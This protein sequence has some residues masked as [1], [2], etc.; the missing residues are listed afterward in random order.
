[1]GVRKTPVIGV[2]ALFVLLQSLAFADEITDRARRLL[3]E[4]NPQAAYQLLQPLES[5]RAGDPEYDYL[6]GIAALDSG[7]R[8]RAVFALERVLAVNPNH[9]QA[10]AEIARAYF[11]L[12]EKENALREFQNVRATNPPEAVKQTIDRYLSALGVGATQLSGFLEIGFG[13]DSNVNSATASNQIAIPALGGIVAT[14]APSGVK[15]HDTF[16][17]AGGGVSVVHGFTREWA[18]V[19]G[20]AVNGK[21]NTHQSDFNTGTVDG[22]LGL[23]WSRGREAITAGYQGQDFRV[24]NDDFRRSNGVVAQ[25][26]HSYSESSQVSLFV[27][28]ANLAYPTQSIRDARRTIGGVAFGYGWDT[29]SKPVVF[30]S[31]YGGSEK[32]KEADQPQLGHKPV[33]VRLGGQVSV[34]ANAV[35]FGLLSYERRVYNGDD[36]IFLVTRR[37]KQSDIRLGVN[38]ALRPGWLLVPQVAYTDNQSNIDLDKYGRTVIS[39]TLRKTF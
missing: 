25:W 12:G 18:V 2:A 39:L 3:Q 15:I 16:T 9:A 7:E 19:A 20:A 13:W 5:Q 29:P 37:D 6:L 10:R 21:F 24:D 38:Y 33:G 32:Q 31:L 26:Q 4:K 36:P 17:T 30:G 27:Q 11:L 14:I 28:E 22:N 34:G 1:M 35:L 23:R 8:E